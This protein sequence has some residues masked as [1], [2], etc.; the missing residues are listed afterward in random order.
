MRASMIFTSNDI[1]INLG[2]ILAGFLVNV[3]HSDKPDIIVG[4][5]LFLLVLQGA[6][7]ILKNWQIEIKKLSKLTNIEFFTE[8]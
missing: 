3:F 2:V 8:L 4:G 1:L 7:R 6:F 5:V